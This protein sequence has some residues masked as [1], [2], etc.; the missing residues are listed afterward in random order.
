MSA[1]SFS[2]ETPAAPPQRL[3]APMWHTAVV[4]LLFAALAIAGVMFRGNG[5]LAKPISS[6]GSL[7][8]SLIGA[9]FGLI[10]LVGLGL[11]KGRTT[12]SDIIGRMDPSFPA[13]VRDAA[14]AA[15][16]W[17]L[18]IG[19]AL[20]VGL[21]ASHDSPDIAGLIP[22]G[23]ANKVLWVGVSF[24]AGIAEE[25]TFRGYLLRQFRAMTGSAWLS[26]V[27]QAAVFSIA[28]GYEGLAACVN[29]AA[30]GILFGIIAIRT[31]N[32]RACMIAHAWTDIA[33]GLL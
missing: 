20:A 23:L 5:G 4:I 7:Y 16:A 8:L 21:F 24:A 33:A 14:I 29:I 1:Q 25:L 15:L 18:W 32:L 22:H 2:G 27:L 13:W 9:E 17:G 3:V 6:Q 28:H 12:I 26:V 10:F 11:R 19:L 31:G 30:F